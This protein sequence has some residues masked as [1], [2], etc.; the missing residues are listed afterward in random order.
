MPRPLRYDLFI[1][2]LFPAPAAFV[3]AGRSLDVVL[4]TTDRVGLEH[5]I[6]WVC[7]SMNVN[8]VVQTVFPGQVRGLELSATTTDM[9]PFKPRRAEVLTGQ[10]TELIVEAGVNR[11]SV[12]LV[13]FVLAVYVHT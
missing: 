6:K 9:V 8:C 13:L 2:V 4:E 10:V 11:L 1:A 3:F 12:W 5:L 7:F